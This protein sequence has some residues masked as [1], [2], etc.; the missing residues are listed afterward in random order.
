MTTVSIG[1]V[2]LPD[3]IKLNYL[4]DWDWLVA[5]TFNNYSRFREF[6]INQV[7]YTIFLLCYFGENAKATVWNRIQTIRFGEYSDIIIQRH[8]PTWYSDLLY[9]WN[10][11]SLRKLR[12]DV[13]PEIR[14]YV[15]RFIIT[16]GRIKVDTAFFYKP[17]IPDEL[18]PKKRQIGHDSSFYRTKSPNDL[19][20][21][22]KNS[23][24][25]SKKSINQKKPPQSLWQRIV[26][27]FR[28]L[29]KAIFG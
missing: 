8:E 2:T 1:S 28:R 10:I 5:D 7:S 17:G 21:Y 13:T 19:C 20:I 15:H 18:L 11:D 4:K 14:H 3:L 6:P 9:D 24:N 12:K 27:W 22:D 25:C 29:W 23:D 16:D 26:D